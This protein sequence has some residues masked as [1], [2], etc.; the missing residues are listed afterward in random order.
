MYGFANSLLHNGGFV[1]FPGY[2]YL[3]NLATRPEYRA[4]AETMAGELTREWIE[5][6]GS[7]SDE[8]VSKEQDEA[9]IAELEEAIHKHDLQNIF[10]TAAMHDSFFGRAQI[11]PRIKGADL[12]LPLVLS[13]A[14]VKRGSLEGFSCVEAMW[15]T[16]NQYDALDPASPHFYKPQSWFM[17]GQLVHATRLM[18]IISRPL[19]DMLKPA[20]NFSGMSMSQLAEPYVQNWLRTRQ[21]VSDLINNF[22][23]TA[24]KTNMQTL[25]Q[26]D[27]EG[28]NDVLARA[29]FFTLTRSNK[30]L[31]LLDQEHEELVQINTPL[32]GLHELQAQSQE[33]MSAVSHIPTMILTG[34]SPTGLNASS[35]GEIR[36]F[37]DW[38]SAQQESVWAR[39]LDVCIKL[40]MLDLWGEI[41]ETITWEYAPLWQTT[42]K[43][44]AEIRQADSAADANWTNLGA[45]SPE[46]V[47]KRLAVD[48]DSGYTGIEADDLP[49]PP[50]EPDGVPFGEEPTELPNA[51]A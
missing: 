22:S 39:P 48:P 10:R 47:R 51:E 40:I 21:S 27:A 2:P 20:Y 44:K 50:P 26:G 28:G 29:D 12:S 1:P 43:E 11:I 49:E 45:I 13:K 35:E 4:F 23:L 5:F 15:T 46:D 24:L 16:P 41:D 31:M 19:P 34:I 7:S 30:G 42:D 14:T 37:Y 8:E 36:V 25:L 9:R 3:A 18:T 38:I 32:S 33:Q 6:S 17:L